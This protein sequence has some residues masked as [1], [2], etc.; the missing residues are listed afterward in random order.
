MTD[1]SLDT[2]QSIF[3]PPTTAETVVFF[4]TLVVNLLNFLP[5]FYALI[6]R[7]FPPMRA[8]HVGITVSIGTGGIIFNISY[9][10][11][12]G[13]AKYN[14]VLGVCK[15]WGAWVMFTLG[16]GIVMSAI[17]MRL[18][19]FY[20]V[21]VTGNSYNRSSSVVKNFLRRFWPFF[22]LWLPTIISSI[23]ISALPG[24][25]GAWLLED[26]GL[27]AC[28][29]SYGY[30]YWIYAYFAAQIILSWVLYFRMRRVAQAFNGFRMAIWTLLIFT[31]ILISSM[32]IN[33]I[34]G[35]N[36]SW[37]RIVIALLNMVMMTIYIWLIFGPP[38]IGHIFW[39]EQTMRNFMNSLH[40]DALIAQ[41]TRAVGL[42]SQMY[43]AYENET[44]ATSPL[45]GNDSTFMNGNHPS[46]HK[47]EPDIMQ[48]EYK[49][50][51]VTYSHNMR[52]ML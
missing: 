48:Y 45:N 52:H 42:Q 17:N 39:R 46:E 27:R 2:A 23:V 44:Y 25:R 8:Q 34:K 32:V 38:V 41:Q 30:T 37:G 36:S 33:I 43:G 4:I 29:F 1:Q 10:L 47:E 40:K 20:R 12:Q 6:Y 50:P 24:P 15:L 11:V 14:G 19:L 49:P 26:H 9:N 28:D 51:H 31:A 3:V 21:F 5:I 13:M 22:A 18:V 35:S 16:L 7:K